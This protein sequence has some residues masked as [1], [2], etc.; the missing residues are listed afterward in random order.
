MCTTRRHN[1]MK[2]DRALFKATTELV[3]W[4]PDTEDGTEL[5]LRNCVLCHSTITDGTTRPLRTEHVLRAVA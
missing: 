1:I 5:E 3:G 2:G 4:Q